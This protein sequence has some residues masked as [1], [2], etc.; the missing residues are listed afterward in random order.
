M[1]LV[2]P[3]P[4]TVE[5]QVPIDLRLDQDEVYEEHHE[6]VLYI[7]VG[8]ALAARALRQAD[9]LAQ[10]P[11]IG[12]AVRAVEE[13]DGEPTFYADRHLALRAGRLSGGIVEY[14]VGPRS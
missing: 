11:V 7:F 3:M 10:R 1:K 6:V 13:V 2:V 4:D 12:L 14:R 5:E 9:A 8:E